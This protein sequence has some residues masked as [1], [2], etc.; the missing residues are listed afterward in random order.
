MNDT[1][2]RSAG[3]AEPPVLDLHDVR[4]LRRGETSIHLNQFS[5][6]VDRGQMVRA[7]LER[8]HNSRQIVSLMLGLETPESGTV[9]FEGR[10]WSEQDYTR[11]FQMRSRIGRVYSGTAWIQ[12]LTVRENIRLSMSHHRV[13]PPE[14]SDRVNTWMERLG[15]SRLSSVQRAVRKRPSAVEPSLLQ[16]C[17]FVRAMC[18]DPAL[19]L[20]ERP[21]SFIDAQFVGHLVDA[22]NELLSRG[23]A[24]VWLANDRQKVL[25]GIKASVRQWSIVNDRLRVSGGPTS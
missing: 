5:A 13:P 11:Q 21:S 23:C 18:I 2:N 4:F 12:S 9:R 14:I 15:G 16:V 7:T 1:K 10:A 20:L 6:S 8:H 25:S 22:V 3:N 19:L 17:Q 24:V